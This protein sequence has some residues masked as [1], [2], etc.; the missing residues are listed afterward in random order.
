MSATAVKTGSEQTAVRTLDVL[1]VQL[2]LFGFIRCC[3]PIFLLSALVLGVRLGSMRLGA[4]SPL[5]PQGVLSTAGDLTSEIGVIVIVTAV[6]TLMAWRKQQG[7]SAQRMLDGEGFS[8]QAKAD[9]LAV[10]VIWIAA[11][12]ASIG[13]TTGLAWA[14][15][16]F[17]GHPSQLP[18]SYLSTYINL[19]IS[20]VAVP[21]VCLSAGLII[22]SLCRRALTATLVSLT[23]TVVATQLSLA[24]DTIPAI[25]WVYA[26]L[27]T[28][29]LE[30]SE[31]GLT[32][33]STGSHVIASVAVI[34]WPVLAVAV[35]QVTVRRAG[36]IAPSAV[37]SAMAKTGRPLRYIAVCATTASL[38][39]F[40]YVVPVAF[41]QEIPW[42]LRPVWRLDVAHHRSSLDIANRYL[43][44]AQA[45]R[46]EEADALSVTDSAPVLLGPY[47]KELQ[48]TT[49]SASTRL[50]E[51]RDGDP[52]AVTVQLSN[53]TFDL[54]EQ[55]LVVG[56]RITGVS[57]DGTCPAARIA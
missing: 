53:G 13:I 48:L 23:L 15:W 20:V 6:S 31:L 49:M 47:F 50:D 26:A 35:S 3:A 56:W 5:D 12:A 7:I 2:K 51:R 18:L 32:S 41:R 36:R 45:G 17:T 9:M 24:A 55:R 46:L 40:G 44:F 34:A 28:S 52:G 11:Q 16:T 29:A 43:A 8:Q 33:P 38:F 42:Q 1:I 14:D 21:V 37:K 4:R 27:P 10:L 19:A 30:V 39:C 25:Q 54:C 22:G 57:F